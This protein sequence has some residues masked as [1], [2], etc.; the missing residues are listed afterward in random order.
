MRSVGSQHCGKHTSTSHPAMSAP[1]RALLRAPGQRHPGISAGS[2]GPRGVCGGGDR[3]ARTAPP[4]LPSGARSSAPLQ[5]NGSWGG[6]SAP[7][8][9]R[10]GRD[11]R[12]LL[13]MSRV[14]PE[15]DARGSG[16]GRSVRAGEAG[17]AAPR[18][19]ARAWAPSAPP[20]PPARGH[21]AVLLPRRE[22]TPARAHR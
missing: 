1:C 17:E 21:G 22:R 16:P 7:R 4:G 9:R 3:G 12:A 5:S 11:L 2:R 10:L 14:R 19:P 15:R 8:D 20:W 18:S 6:R 13:P